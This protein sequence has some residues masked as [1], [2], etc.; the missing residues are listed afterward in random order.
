MSESCF[1]STNEK[2]CYFL[3]SLSDFSSYQGWFVFFENGW[4]LFKIIDNVS[5]DF[6]VSLGGSTLF[7][8]SSSVQDFF[9]DLDFRFI[10][11]FDDRGRIYD[12][13]EKD[14]LVVVKYEKFFDNSLSE[15]LFSKFLVIRGL[16]SFSFLR[17]WLKKFY[18]YD[19]QRGALSEL[20]VFRLLRGSSKRL[21][22]GFGSTEEEAIIN[23]LVK[24]KRVVGSSS[25]LLPDSAQ[26]KLVDVERDALLSVD[27]SFSSCVKKLSDGFAIFAGYPWF[28]QVWARDECISLIGLFLQKKFDVAKKIILRNLKSISAEGILPNRYPESVLGSADAA[29]WLFQRSFLFLKSVKDYFSKKELLLLEEKLDLFLNNCKDRSYKGLIY[30]GSKETWMDT[31]I[32]NSSRDG[33]RVEIQALYLSA[34]E[35]KIYLRKLA[36][37][38]GEVLRFRHLLRKKK[39]L[40]RNQ[41]IKDKIIHDGF[42]NG[43]IDKSIRPNVFLAFYAYQG[44][45]MKH[46]WEATFNHVLSDCWLVWGGLSSIG[47]SHHLFRDT[48]SGMSNESYHHGDS[49]FFINNIVA[50]VLHKFDSKKYKGQIKKIKQASIHELLNEGFIGYCAE[51]SSAKVLEARGCLNQAWSNATLLELLLKT[52]GF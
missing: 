24:K 32:N 29:G 41:L 15:K 31:S 13:Y 17:D 33:A 25:S 27:A 26:K 12:V 3:S 22:F 1:F 38:D 42:V 35:L 14:G 7:L 48:Y 9:I 36:C 5:G 11:D 43:V 4:D 39:T 18:P 16:D 30:S 40:I 19:A 10:H 21:V 50:L 34:L 2:G 28:Y 20:Y 6:S 46:Q 37:D 8:D 52:R 51:V 49:W 47:K 45:A 44:L 23:T